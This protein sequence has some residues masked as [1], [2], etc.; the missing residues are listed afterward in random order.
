[1]NKV[2]LVGRLTK[3]MGELKGPENSKVGLFTMAV[4]RNYT[5]Q[6]GNRE[7]DFIPVKVF[8]RLA[9]NCKK[10][11][12]KGSLVSVDACI[13][14]GSYEKDGKTF[15]TMDVIADNVKFHVSKKNKDNENQDGESFPGSTA[16]EPE[17]DWPY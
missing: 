9:E 5:N 3:D 6:Q 4:D 7:A 14:T 12:G 8:K 2:I 15:Y 10:Y 11:L 1:M 17:H 16:Y 13:K